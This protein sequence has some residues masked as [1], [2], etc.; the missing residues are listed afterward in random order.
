MICYITVSRGSEIFNLTKA[1]CTITTAGVILRL[2]RTKSDV[3]GAEKLVPF[4]RVG[5]TNVGRDLEFLLGLPI[6]EGQRIWREPR[7]GKLTFKNEATEAR[8]RA[9]VKEAFN[10]DV[11]WHSF[12]KGSTSSLILRGTPIE[13]IVALGTW[14]NPNSI[15]P[16]VAN[17][18]RT[19]PTFA[20]RRV[21]DMMKGEAIRTA[22]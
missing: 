10:D 14:A 17:T 12:R 1:D 18:I 4:S 16:Y 13:A 8:M 15:R 19:D 2:P 20:A 9:D 5:V 11:T 22:L 7:G 3:V 6:P 21:G